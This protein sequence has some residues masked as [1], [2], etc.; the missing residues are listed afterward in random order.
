M[1][2]RPVPRVLL[3][4][5]DAVLGRIYSCALVAAGFQVDLAKD[6]AE[7]LELLLA[8]SYDALVS[9]LCMPRMTGLDLLQEVRRMRRDVPVVLM[10]AQLDTRIYELARD[11][12][13]VRY[14]IKPM[15]MEQLARAVERAVA[16]SAARGRE[17]KANRPAAK[18]AGR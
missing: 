12:G 1:S 16:F 8:G 3:V 14:L 13:A 7:G 4:E 5:D 10:T 9:D 6:G 15:K 17:S 11:M 18:T 2:P